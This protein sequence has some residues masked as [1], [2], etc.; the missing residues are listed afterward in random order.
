MN[1]RVLSASSNPLQK[2]VE[3]QG[4]R[5]D[6][7][8]RLHVYPIQIPSL[9]DRQEDI[10]FLASHFLKRYAALQNKS[11]NSFHEEIVDYMKM[12]AW[13]GNIRQLENLVERLVTLTN[14]E[15]KVLDRTVLPKDLNKEL[16]KLENSNQEF[17]V[18]QYLNDMLG[19]YEEQVIRQALTS[20]KWN[21]SGTARSLKI[22][23]QTL[24]T[25]S[26]SWVL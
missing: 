23:E 19:E 15:K 22:S 16:R 25:K 2:L 4:F 26:Q 20:N 6:L 11:V 13:P 7:F 21:Q 24:P 3:T 1:V 9:D 12:R 5:E 17:H 10:P 8:Y 14:A 18:T